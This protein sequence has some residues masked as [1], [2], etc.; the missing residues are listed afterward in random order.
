MGVAEV[1]DCHATNSAR[2]A[3]WPHYP[4]LMLISRVLYVTSAIALFTLRI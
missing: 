4:Y 1:F 3:L 2:A